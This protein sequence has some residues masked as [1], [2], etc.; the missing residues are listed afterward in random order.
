MGRPCEHTHSMLRA[1]LRAYVNTLVLW[2]ARVEVWLWQ[3]GPVVC[4]AL[5]VC[6]RGSWLS[7]DR[8]KLDER[9]DASGRS[10]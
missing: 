9:C 7:Q 5:K 1:C 3:P 4:G 10:C 8:E 2:Q 6:A